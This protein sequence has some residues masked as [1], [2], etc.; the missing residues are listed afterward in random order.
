[1]SDII[2]VH[3][4]YVPKGWPDLSADAGV[5]APWLRVESESDAII[6]MGTREF[7]RIQSDAWDYEVRLR[8]MDADGVR[9]QVVSPT[10][11]FF[12]Y[13][14]TPEEA[15]RIARIFNDLALTIVEPAPDRLVPFCQVPLQDTDAACRELERCVENGH[16]G[17][18][19][20]NHV[21]DRDLDSEG[22]VTF[23]QHCA[24]LSVP[25]FVHPWDMASSPRLDRWMAQWLAGMPAETHL[26]ILSLILGGGFDR[27]DESLRIAFAHGG[28][29]FAFWLGRVDNAWHRRHDIIGTSA[30]PP[31]R[32]VDRFYVDSVVFDE[33]A[34]RLLVDTM[35]SERVLVGSDYPYPLGERPVGSVVRKSEFLTPEARAMIEHENAMRFLGLS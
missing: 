13:G 5:D 27:I 23:L 15:E 24:S 6:M 10:P 31:S 30:E 18:E 16:R 7:R 19:I 14:R 35:G 32:Y 26:S 34:L 3:T 1:M 2:D 25:V 29:S 4:H 28:G 11:A 33:R 8:D 17:V 9:A 20:G 22:I 12:N 21:G